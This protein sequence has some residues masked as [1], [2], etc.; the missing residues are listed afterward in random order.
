[1]ERILQTIM[2]IFPLGVIGINGFTVYKCF[3]LVPSIIAIIAATV[4]FVLIAEDIRKTSEKEDF[5]QQ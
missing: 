4:L 2:C 5:W 3:G 1:M